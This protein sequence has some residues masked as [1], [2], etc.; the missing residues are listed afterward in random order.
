VGFVTTNSTTRA[1]LGSWHRFVLH[2][3]IAGTSSRVDAAMDGT[4]VPGLTLTGQNL[5][6]S[7]IGRLQLG[8]TASDRTYDIAFDDV[9]VAAGPL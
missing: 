7:S 8:E 9:A 6:T 1:P 4:P 5:G 2:A 3:A